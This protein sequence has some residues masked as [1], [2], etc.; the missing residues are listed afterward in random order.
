MTKGCTYRGLDL[1]S[2]YCNSLI[3]LLLKVTAGD[4]EGL[5]IYKDSC[6]L[7]PNLFQGY[8]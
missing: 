2:F 5:T 3:R 1:F 7:Q 6:S 4:K 8:H